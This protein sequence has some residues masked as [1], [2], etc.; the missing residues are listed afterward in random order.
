MMAEA[1]EGFQGTISIGGRNINNLRFADDI[2]LLAGSNQELAELT[3]RLDRTAIS[4]GMEINQDKSK[5]L[6]NNVKSTQ[7]DIYIR[8]GKLETVH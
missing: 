8:Q 5:I 3:A 7:P 2:D 6:T 1:L 4:Y